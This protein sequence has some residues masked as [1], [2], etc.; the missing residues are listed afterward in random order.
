MSFFY[1]LIMGN[2]YLRNLNKLTDE[3]GNILDSGIL[4][5][6]PQLELP[7]SILRKGVNVLTLEC[8]NET[9]SIQLIK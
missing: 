3:Q 8:V 7:V 2:Q 1:D 4:E 5:P 9:K 6:L